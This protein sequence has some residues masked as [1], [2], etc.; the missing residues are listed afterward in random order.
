[1][2]RR[3]SFASTLHHALVFSWA[4][5]LRDAAE[6]GRGI[7]AAD[8]DGLRASATSDRRRSRRPPDFPI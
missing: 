1:M 3:I 6:I 2:A 5:S 8:H 7:S 4:W